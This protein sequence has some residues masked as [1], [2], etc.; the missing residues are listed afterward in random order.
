MKNLSAR[1]FFTII[2][3]MIAT[4]FVAEGII[5]TILGG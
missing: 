4:T 3:I 2:A 5:R 1:G